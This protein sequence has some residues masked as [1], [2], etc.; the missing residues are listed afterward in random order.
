M[1][2][3]NR[4]DW[5]TIFNA[6]F[7][8]KSPKDS[9]LAYTSKGGGALCEHSH[10]ISIWLHFANILK[11]G[12]VYKVSSIMKFSKKNTMNYDEQ[13]FLILETEKKYLGDIIQ[14][15]ITFP[16]EK[17]LRIQFENGFLEW[18]VNIKEN[19]DSVIF[20]CK[21]KFKSYL[22]KK[23]RPDDFNGLVNHLGK[24]L[25]NK[26]FVKNSPIAV[27]MSIKIIKIINKA[28]KSKNKKALKI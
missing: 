20:Q 14:D 8:F 9:Y 13:A 27:D 25:K 4:E 28:I 5:T 7:W 2:A 26:N 19:Y 1:S 12:K 22:I 17:S 18:K 6:H 10:A 24:A 11:L 23:N 15:V 16:P 21:K 3:R